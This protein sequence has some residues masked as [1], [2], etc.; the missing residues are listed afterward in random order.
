MD[1]ARIANRIRKNVESICANLSGFK[2]EL[3]LRATMDI[4]ALLSS[5][6]RRPRSAVESNQASGAPVGPFFHFSFPS[7]KPWRESIDH[8][9]MLSCG[10]HARAWNIRSLLGEHAPSCAGEFCS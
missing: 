5:I 6:T 8:D 2:V 7:R 10:T 4:R 3:L 9:Q 1:H